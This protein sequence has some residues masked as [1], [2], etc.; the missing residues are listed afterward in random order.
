[1]TSLE[2]V[3]GSDRVLNTATMAGFES[4]QIFD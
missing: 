3:R 1:M 4:Y 2:Q